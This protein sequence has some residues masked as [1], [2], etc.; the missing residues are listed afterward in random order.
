[1]KVIRG[2]TT[3]IVVWMFLAVAPFVQAADV[4]GSEG[5][6]GPWIGLFTPDLKD[7]NNKLDANGFP[8]VDGAI[9]LFGG[10]GF[11]IVNDVRIGGFGGGGALVAKEGGK[12]TELSVGF[13][14]TQVA[15]VWSM[16]RFNLEVG[17]MFGG[18]G[19]TIVLS[20]GTPASGDDAISD[21]YDTV[22]DRGFWLLGPSVG[23][24]WNFTDHVAMQ[25]SGGYI[26]TIGDWKHRSGNSELA[27]FPDMNGP[28]FTIGIVFGGSHP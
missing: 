5:G 11:G 12:R 3:A 20:D 15:Y 7:F 16:D 4:S 22:I 27:G 6:G 9:T 18:G 26:H 28:Y 13:G 24:R 21:R 8:T 17:G 23:A 14:G 1:M 10:G 2:I 19:S 25:M